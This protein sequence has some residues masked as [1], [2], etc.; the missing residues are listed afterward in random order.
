[1]EK[2]NVGNRFWKIPP[3]ISPCSSFKK[4]KENQETFFSLE[5]SVDAVSSQTTSLQILVQSNF[6]PTVEKHIQAKPV[7]KGLSPFHAREVLGRDNWE[8]DTKFV[9]AWWKYKSYLIVLYQPDLLNAFVYERFV[10]HNYHYDTVSFRVTAKFNCFCY[11]S[12]RKYDR[13][14]YSKRG[15]C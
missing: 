15:I 12:I 3:Y 14:K 1:M 10:L 6:N 4:R 9:L 2:A 8:K 11:V 7:W 5:K 13:Y